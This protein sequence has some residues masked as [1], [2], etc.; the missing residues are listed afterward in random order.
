MTA[1]DDTDGSGGENV[2]LEALKALAY[3]GTPLEVATNF[4]EQGN[5]CFRDRQWKDAVEFYS[6]GVVVLGEER[7]KRRGK[8]GEVVDGG[9]GGYGEKEKIDKLEEILLLNRAACN[10]ELRRSMSL[11]SN[12]LTQ[13]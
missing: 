7:R 5:E 3:E 8:N 13:L 6:K 9:V 4:R 10:L 1:L 11:R 12:N 2:E